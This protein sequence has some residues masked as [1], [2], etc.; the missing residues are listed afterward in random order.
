MSVAFQ[1]EDDLV[2]SETRFDEP[3]PEGRHPGICVDVIPAGVEEET[4]DGKVTRN[5]KVIFV[6]QVF[7]L[8]DQKDQYGEPVKTRQSNGAPFLI[9][10][11]VTATINAFSRCRLMLER[12]RNKPLTP[13][14]L[15][16]FALVAVKGAPAYLN[17]VHTLK[18]SFIYAN[19][20]DDL[21]RDDK[22]Q[23]RKFSNVEYCNGPVG[24]SLKAEL[25]HYDRAQ[26]LQKYERM[27]AK[28]DQQVAS[29]S[30]P[31]NPKDA[32]A[33]VDAILS[34][35]QKDNDIPF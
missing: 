26:V 33:S 25:E 23:E 14:E 34:K 17:I 31:V 13:E 9:D 24:A 16:N 3:A 1:E 21:I 5:K 15:K 12:W 35:N 19:L 27:R 22:G 18:N 28:R 8:P 7:P 29:A 30:A 6:W 20:Q 4:F 2:L 10:T 11:K 32:W